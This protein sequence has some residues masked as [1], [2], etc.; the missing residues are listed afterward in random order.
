M[1]AEWIHERVQTRG[2]EKK[3]LLSPA[4]STTPLTWLSIPHPIVIPTEPFQ[5]WIIVQVLLVCNP[6][7]FA[8]CTSTF[9]KLC[10][11]VYSGM[12][13]SAQ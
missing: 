1:E 13:K 3:N 12:Q 11:N 9:S 8:V 10:K 6:I 5:L 7:L 4:A 2:G